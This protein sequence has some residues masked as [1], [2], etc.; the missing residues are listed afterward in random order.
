MRDCSLDKIVLSNITKVLFGLLLQLS[1]PVLAG[2]YHIS[3]ST[4]DGGGG[5]SSGGQYELEGTIGQP[6]AAYS[7]GGNYELLGGFWPGGPLCSQAPSPTRRPARHS[8]M[9]NG[10]NSASSA[11]AIGSE[12]GSTTSLALI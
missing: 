11:K 10:T 2:D 4:I 12:R 6:D 5:V 8:R 9:A 3:W 7:Y 1:W